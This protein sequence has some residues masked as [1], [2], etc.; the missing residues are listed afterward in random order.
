MRVV[1]ERDFFDA[2]VEICDVLGDERLDPLALGPLDDPRLREEGGLR[3]ERLTSTVPFRMAECSSLIGKSGFVTL[4]GSENAGAAISTRSLSGAKGRAAS[5]DASS[6][7]RVGWG[8][9]LGLEAASEPFPSRS[10]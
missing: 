8:I 7:A 4:V 6:W 2:P 9:V 3:V 1:V 5:P 10:A